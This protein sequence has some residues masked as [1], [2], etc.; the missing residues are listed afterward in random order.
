MVD[1]TLHHLESR[2][3]NIY[4]FLTYKFVAEEHNKFSIS[5]YVKLMHIEKK[6]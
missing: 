1:I 2:D 5:C 6:I 3:T 4:Y